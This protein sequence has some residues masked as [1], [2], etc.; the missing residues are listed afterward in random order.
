MKLPERGLERDDLFARM[1]AYRDQDMNW[2]SGRTFAYIYDAGREAE[3]V[4][5]EAFASFLTEN[6]LDPTVFPSLLKFETDLVGMATAHLSGGDEAVGSFT[7]GGTESIM[8]ACKAARDQAR[9]ARPNLARPEIVLPTTAHAAFH[10]AAEYLCLERV[11]VPVD[12]E[13]FKADPEAIR[14]A[15]TPNTVMLVASS[16][17]YAHGVIDPV[18]EIAALAREHD[19]WLHVDACVGGFLLPFFR[20]LGAEVPP[21][22]FSVPGVTSISM[23]LHKYAFT[24]KGASLVLYRTRSLRR[25][26]IFAC[27]HWTGY[28]VINPTVQSSRSGGPLAAAWAVLN[29]L[30][31]DG[32]MDL[33]KRTLDATRRLVEGIEAIDG[34]DV[35]AEPEFCMVAATS[36]DFSVFH[37]VDEMKERGWYIQPQ[38][39]FGSSRENIHFS[40]HPGNADKIDAMLEALQ[41]SVEAA[42]ARGGGS[43]LAAQVAKMAESLPLDQLDESTF[44][45]LLSVAGVDGVDL[46]DR[47]AEINEMLN[48]LPRPLSEKLLIEFINELYVCRDDGC[49]PRAA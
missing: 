3:R 22:D 9:K 4:G 15:I 16:P 19:L 5:K 44:G 10:K 29:H 7:S 17:S 32:Y 30:G 8:L 24:P 41:E 37:I 12:P 38:L 18:E 40:L 47:M 39:A 34:L 13:T 35:M 6:A 2:R 20:R 23:D 27:G 11:M 46:P 36:D 26:Q 43:G 1:D 42:R 48:A 14:E 31:D 21:F 45:Q 33:A 49:P 25:H 28:T